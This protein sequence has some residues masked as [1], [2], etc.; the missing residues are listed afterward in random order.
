MDHLSSWCDKYT[1]SGSKMS[2]LWRLNKDVFVGPGQAAHTHSHIN[3][4]ASPGGL[5]CPTWVG[6]KSPLSAG[7]LVAARREIFARAVVAP[8]RY[9]RH[10]STN[11]GLFVLNWHLT[12]LFCLSGKQDYKKTKP[13]LRAA[14]LKAEAKKNSSGFR[15]NLRSAPLST[16]H[17]LH[18]CRLRLCQPSFVRLTTTIPS[19]GKVVTHLHLR[20]RD[21]A[22]ASL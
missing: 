18:Y 11:F 21:A 13:A 1:T 19:V 3:I 14:R 9:N 15:V 6:H 12:R 10:L 4:R 16:Q 2:F 7:D 20:P 22:L 8:R 17:V 5:F